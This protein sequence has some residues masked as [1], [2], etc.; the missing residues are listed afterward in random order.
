LGIES[1]PEKDTEEA[2][3]QYLGIDALINLINKKTLTK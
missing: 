2:T 1:N 3:K